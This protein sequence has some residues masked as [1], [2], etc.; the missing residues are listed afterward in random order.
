MLRN[1]YFF[2][3]LALSVSAVVLFACVARGQILNVTDTTST[4][5]PGAGHDYIKMLNETVNPANGSVSIRIQT[6][7]PPGRR[8]T[9]PFA[10][11]Y[12][13]NGVHH[14]ESMANTQILWLSNTSFVSKGGWS[15]SVPMLSAAYEHKSYTIPPSGP[16]YS[17]SYWTDFVFQEPSGGRH[18][19]G[20]ARIV[21]SDSSGCSYFG[22]YSVSS[23]G[24]SLFK[25]KMG[26]SVPMPLVISDPDGTVY[27]FATYPPEYGPSQTQQGLP[28]FVE[29]RNGNKTTLTDLGGGKFTYVDTLGRTAVSSSGLGATGNTVSIYGLSQPYTMTWGSVSYNYSV[30]ATYVPG[31][32]TTGCALVPSLSGSQSVISAITLPNNAHYYLYYDG[33]YGL[34]NKIVYPTGGYVRYVWGMNAQS[35]HG[36]FADM[37]GNPAACEEYFGTPAV[38]HRYVSFNGSTEVLQQDF[39]YSTTWNGNQWTS[40]QTTVTTHDLLRGGQ[41]SD[42]LCLLARL[43]PT[44]SRRAGYC[45]RPDSC[46][47]DGY[48]QRLERHYRT[49]SDQTV[50]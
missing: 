29:D 39:T 5:V 31:S 40:K 28:D 46:G 2:E 7:V 1:F 27:H 21:D 50:V 15:Y 20:L 19:L 48:L 36:T 8:L 16:T 43:G 9:I 22:I 34:L 47:T 41:F 4:P 18:A 11:A 24:D 38:L 25:A 26:S 32:S 44:C 17:C 42:N 33:T 30:G 49:H 23:G 14:P 3:K 45:S 10:F 37:Y 13:S 12:D 6:P 35:E